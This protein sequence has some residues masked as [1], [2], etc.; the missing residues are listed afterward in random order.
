MMMHGPQ[1][2][3]ISKHFPAMRVGVALACALMLSACM[4]T[5]SSEGM[6]G[7]EESVARDLG[8]QATKLA[9]SEQEAEIATRVAALLRKPISADD[10]VQI[11]LWNNRGLQA[12]FNE[13]GVADAQ[14][15]QASLPPNPRISLSRVT[16]PLSLEIER[17]IAGSILALA[18]LPVR[19]EIARAKF[20]QAQFRTVETTLKLAADTRRQ[21]Y[22]AL[23]A[24]ELVGVLGEV[25]NTSQVSADLTRRLGE[26]GSANKR[27]Q[28]RDFV[29]HAETSAQ[30]AQARI[31]QRVEREKLVRLLG[32]WGRD[33]AALKLPHSLPAL[34]RL[35]SPKEIEAEALRRRIDLQ[36]AKA[37][38]DALAKSLG[39]TQATR[40]VSDIDL[41]AG[42]ASEREFKD[43]GMGGLERERVKRRALE[44]EIEIPI[45]DFGA[46]RVAQAEESYMAAANKFAEKAVN[47]RSEAREAYQVWRGTHDV[48]RLYQGQVL[49]LR[50]TLQDE[51]LL[52]YNGML[53]DISQVIT[54]ARGRM[55]SRVA[56]VNARRDFWIA[57]VDFKHALIGG[58]MTGAGGTSGA[59]AA[60]GGSTGEPG[61]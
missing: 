25:Q 14:R 23:A 12:A 48:S 13:L 42:R 54:E 60:A 37:D 47:I 4:T 33:H 61:H 43:D 29:F 49:P 27:D 24:N 55:M 46:A 26:A 39:L 19:A 57:D 11:A 50:K 38:L 8:M 15:A 7:V 5:S 28:A 41:A 56:A 30:L 9:S 52:H 53:I 40:F 22:R 51:S 10:A 2:F 21:Y 36:I 34:P 45:F 6:M 17:R 18:T 58:G 16:A 59:M 35:V 31:A 20:R 3:C 44:L 1:A 32:L